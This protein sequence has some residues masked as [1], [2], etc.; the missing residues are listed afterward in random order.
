M[1]QE[2]KRMMWISSELRYSFVLQVFLLLKFSGYI[3][4]SSFI[5]CESHELD[6]NFTLSVYFFNV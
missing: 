6:H 5:F 3:F 1:V 2:Y 4:E